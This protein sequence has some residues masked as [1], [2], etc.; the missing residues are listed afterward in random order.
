MAYHTLRRTI[1]SLAA[2]RKAATTPQLTEHG[3]VKASAPPPAIYIHA[4]ELMKPL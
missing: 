1:L 4:F 2:A 3:A